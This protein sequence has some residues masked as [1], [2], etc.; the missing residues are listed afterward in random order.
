MII[1]LESGCEYSEYITARKCAHD[2]CEDTQ[3][4]VVMFIGKAKVNTITSEYDNG[5]FVA[6]NEENNQELYKLFPKQLDYQWA[7]ELK[8]A[9][10]SKI[11]ELEAKREKYLAII[12]RNSLHVLCADDHDDRCQEYLEASWELRD[13]DEELDK[14]R[15]ELEILDK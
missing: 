6:F 4:T 1:K 9:T 5:E 7:E 11:A 10:N 12:R 14:L 13:I 8:E 15:Y 3:N 2:Y